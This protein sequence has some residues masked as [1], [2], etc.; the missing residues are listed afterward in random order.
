[1]KEESAQKAGSNTNLFNQLLLWQKFLI[2]GVLAII[3]ALIPFGA[4]LFSAQGDIAVT[5]HEIDGIKPSLTMQKLVQ[6]TQQHSNLSAM[7][8]AGDTT[9]ETAREAK[10][11]E[12]TDT[13]ATMFGVVKRK[14]ND[15][16]FVKAWAATKERAQG[17]L[18]QIKSAKLNAVQSE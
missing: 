6:L 4:Y 10:A 3:L 1:M 7:A 15:P 5:S 13:I 2:L 18:A 16:L 17:L 8:L 9:G 12:I 11:K 14:I